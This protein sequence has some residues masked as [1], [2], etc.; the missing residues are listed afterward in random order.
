MLFGGGATLFRQE[1]LR[2]SSNLIISTSC[3]SFQFH[4]MDFVSV[5]LSLALGGP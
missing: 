5:I 3:N 2:S 4:H 1:I